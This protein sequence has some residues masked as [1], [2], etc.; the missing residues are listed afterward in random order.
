MENK[1]FFEFKYVCFLTVSITISKSQNGLS[2]KKVALNEGITQANGDLLFTT[3]ADCTPP[4]GWLSQT[5]P[6]FQDDVGLVIGSSPFSEENSIWSKLL[7][8]DNSLDYVLHF[9][10]RAGILG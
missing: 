10:Q 6:L 2:P 8:L 7:G 9:G 3:D 5:V 1:L 4:P